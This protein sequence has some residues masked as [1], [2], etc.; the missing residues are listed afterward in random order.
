MWSGLPSSP[1]SSFTALLKR[2]QPTGHLLLLNLSSPSCPRAFAHGIPLPEVSSRVWVL[3]SLQ[4]TAPTSPRKTDLLR[5]PGLKWTPHPTCPTVLFDFSFFVVSIMNNNSVYLC[6][7]FLVLSL[8][9]TTNST[10]QGLSPHPS[11]QSGAGP[12]RPS[13]PAWCGQGTSQ[14]LSLSWW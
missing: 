7:C 3:P 4:V 2:A 8:C 1:T 10:G 9:E 14:G 6:T 5:P 11:T 13:R 12:G